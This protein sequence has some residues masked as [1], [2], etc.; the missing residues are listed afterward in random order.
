MERGLGGTRI[1]SPQVV[2]EH[3]V[4]QGNV[5]HQRSVIDGKQVACSAQGTTADSRLPG[6][7]CTS[8]IV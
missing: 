5:R 2:A 4:A 1:F 7:E 8:V 6:R 3:R